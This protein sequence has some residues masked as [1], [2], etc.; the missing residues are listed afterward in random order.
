MGAAL[1]NVGE[2]VLPTLLK[3]NLSMELMSTALNTLEETGCSTEEAVEAAGG[4]KRP[5]PAPYMSSGTLG[6]D[7]FD[8]TTKAGRSQLERDLVR[9]ENY[10][11]EKSKTVLLS[12][13]NNAF[14]F[15]FPDEEPIATNRTEQ[16]K[17]NIGTV[18]NKIETLCG[19]NRPSQASSVMAMVS[20][21][22]LS[23]LRGGGFRSTASTPTSTAR[24]TSP[25]RR[26]RR[27]AT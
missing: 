3:N 5:P 27:R 10:S 6:L 9:P 20:Q 23:I 21:S 4:G 18:M 2:S 11:Y 8:G 7:A 14:T 22:G 19:K 25:C 17:K 1:N 26:T 13:E 12:K 24:A 16:G 15:H